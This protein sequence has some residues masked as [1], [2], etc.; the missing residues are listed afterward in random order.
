MDNGISFHKEALTTATMPAASMYMAGHILSCRDMAADGS[1][2]GRMGRAG[3][4]EARGDVPGTHG[5]ALTH[6]RITPWKVQAI[7][8]G[9]G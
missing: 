9:A 7:D 3:D 6:C 2:S 4:D 8:E 1:L 5:G